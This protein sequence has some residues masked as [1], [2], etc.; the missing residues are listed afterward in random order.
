V[1][2]HLGSVW[3]HHATGWVL[4][5]A[6]LWSGHYV[7]SSAYCNSQKLLGCPNQAEWDGR[8]ILY[9]R[10]KR[11]I[12]NIGDLCRKAEGKRLLGRNRR[13]W[14]Y[15]IKMDSQWKR[16]E[17]HGLNSSGSA[18]GEAVGHCENGIGSMVHGQ[19]AILE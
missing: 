9:V 6:V 19:Q 5:C 10:D 13:E 14:E 2:H 15:N 11:E 8:G 4:C 1:P 17:G 16:K 18:E 7:R 12:Y 3:R